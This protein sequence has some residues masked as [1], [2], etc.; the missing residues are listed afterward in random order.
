LNQPG[1]REL[2]T[3][4]RR[5]TGA[6]PVTHH[7]RVEV[8]NAINLAAFRG[9]ID[10]EGRMEAANEFSGDFREGRLSRTDILWRAALDRAAELSQLYTRT[11]GTRAA[12][13]LHVACA[14]ELKLPRFLTFD[15]RQAKLATATGLKLI[16]L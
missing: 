3:W 9:E 14:L 13:V 8:T 16:R 15:D 7:G 10:E 11:L 6:L 12:D 2:S 1:I 4:R 5:M